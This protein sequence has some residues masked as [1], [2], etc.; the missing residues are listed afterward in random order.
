MFFPL[1]FSFMSAGWN[2]EATVKSNLTDSQRGEICERL[3]FEP[4]PDE[5]ITTRYFPGFLQAAT[6]LSV[7]I[8]NIKSEE[9]F[10]SRFHGRIINDGGISDYD[11]TAGSNVY[12]IE[13]F[14]FDTR[15][16]D[17]ACELIFYEEDGKN[18]ARFYIGG[19]IPEL[20]NIYEFL[21]DP[22]QPYRSSWMFVSCAVVEVSLA[23]YLI[24]QKIAR[25]VRKG[26][27]KR[28]A[29]S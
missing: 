16:K 1:L 12:H 11:D 6:T 2:V 24:A 28:A 5:T 29:I 13:I 4:S 20:K 19:Y 26:L 7:Y 3:K 17:Y 10:L 25:E 27:R 21:H 18:T 15:P 22:L 8:E 9:D 23:A 14:A